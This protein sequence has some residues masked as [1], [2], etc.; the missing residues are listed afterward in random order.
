M[1]KKIAILFLGLFAPED[2]TFPLRYYSTIIY[3]NSKMWNG[4]KV[5]AAQKE[6]L[7]WISNA[8]IKMFLKAR[9][10]GL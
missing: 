5:L 8:H 10:S 7:S 2:L 6:T 4:E 3:L 9:N 1:E